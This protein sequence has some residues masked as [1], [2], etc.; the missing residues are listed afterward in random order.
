MRA[1]ARKALAAST[2]RP[3]CAFHAHLSDENARLPDWGRGRHGDDPRPSGTEGADD[4]GGPGLRL[5]RTLPLSP[6]WTAVRHVH[7]A[8]APEPT[9]AAEA[10]SARRIVELARQLRLDDALS[11][12]RQQRAQGYAP[13]GLLC[14]RAHRVA[15][16]PATY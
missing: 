4:V 10:P 8:A 1:R 7:T 3:R 15:E 2:D 14:L 12:Y 9:V 16:K 13:V 11:L 5:P 6:L